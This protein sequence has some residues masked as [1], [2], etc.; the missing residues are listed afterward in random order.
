VESRLIIDS[1]DEG[2]AEDLWQWLQQHDALRGRVR[3]A[4]RE[5]SRTTS[6]APP[7][8]SA[9]SSSDRAPGSGPSWRAPWCEAWQE[10]TELHAMA[11]RL[12]TQ[13]AKSLPSNSTSTWDAY[14]QDQEG[15][16]PVAFTSHVRVWLGLVDGQ[17]D[18]CFCA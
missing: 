3:Q 6:R 10:H 17:I 2:A 16:Y 14:H 5:A 8:R 13:Q 15:R 1:A 7:P 12:A 4:Q 18:G 9:S 11:P